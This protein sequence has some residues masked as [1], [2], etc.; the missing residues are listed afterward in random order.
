MFDSRV[1]LLLLLY[2]PGTI[3]FEIVLLVKRQLSRRDILNSLIDITNGKL[4]TLRDCTTRYN[5]LSAPTEDRNAVRPTTM[6][7]KIRGPVKP[8]P[9]P[10]QCLIRNSECI[11]FKKTVNMDDS[12]EVLNVDFELWTPEEDDH[13]VGDHSRTVNLLYDSLSH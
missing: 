2:T 6:I 10:Q 9:R 13:G 4:V 3:T 8:R 7:N 12:R 1:K 5:E 11:D